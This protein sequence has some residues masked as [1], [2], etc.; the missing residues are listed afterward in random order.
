MKNLLLYLGVLGLIGCAYVAR[1]LAQQ[2][3]SAGGVPSHIVVTVEPKRGNE[4]STIRQEDVMV[5]EGQDRDTV[6]GWTPLKG[7]RAGLELFVLID[8]E[9]STT[10]GNQ[11]DDIRK[12]INEQPAST[13]VGV[14]YMQNGIAR[15]LQEP[16]TEHDQAAKALRLPM[17]VGGA[18]SSP[19]FALSDLVKKWPHSNER[20]AVL[21]V[22][23][24]IDRYYGTGDLQ[25]P[26]L[27]AAIDEAAKAGIIVSAIYS[28]G[29]GHFGHSYWLNYWG[30]IYL[31][32]LADKTGGEAYYI[33]FTGAPVTFT[34]Y[35]ESLNRRLGNQYL[36]EFL[37]KPPKKA[38]WAP[39]RLRT[40]VQN[41]DL[42][43]AGRVWVSP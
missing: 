25:D 22:S 28:P 21:M 2:T 35:L 30:Q 20:R 23:D 6:T 18:N 24:G 38:G 12:F 32:E 40:E 8:D 13:K 1:A 39:I 33:G 9:L 26:Y 7:D 41:V 16:T 36:L 19:Y 43:S 27:E 3:P 31:S 5:F 42:V 11:L 15:V 34:P 37:A 10:V 29:A 17:G 14:A 4:A